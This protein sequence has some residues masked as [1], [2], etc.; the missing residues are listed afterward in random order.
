MEVNLGVNLKLSDL[1]IW[2][3]TLLGVLLLF[4]AGIMPFLVKIYYDGRIQNYENLTQL[5]PIGDFIGG[6]TVAFLTAASVALLLATI[7]MQRKEIKISQQS[8][9]ELVK[10]TEAS[11]KQAEEARKETQITNDTMKKQQF[12]TTFFNMLNLLQQIVN[13]MR[14][15]KYSSFYGTTF[16]YTG[17]EV[18]KRIKEAYDKILDSNPHGKYIN[19]SELDEMFKGFLDKYSNEIG[20]YMRFNY[21]IVKFIVDNVAN[22]H[23][24]QKNIYKE[25]GRDTIIGDRRYYFGMLR[26]QWSTSELELILINSLYGKH[27]KFK[28]LILKYDVLDIEER[29]NKTEMFKLKESRE[30]LQVY[31][32]LIE[33]KK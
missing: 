27:Y 25:T 1:G 31:K 32:E 23:N 14:E 28:N 4:T 2:G 29:D 16:D 17:R 20:H 12:E 19:Q 21:R 8:I 6:T 15:T 3:F 30:N 24:E 5:G 9:E 7:I 18:F 10:Q 11:V 33:V 13:N 26:A 22:D